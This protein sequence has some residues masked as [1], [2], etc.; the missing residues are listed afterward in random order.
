MG[1][2]REAFGVSCDTDRDLSLPILIL[3]NNEVDV[4]LSTISIV[5]DNSTTR[6]CRESKVAY[7]VP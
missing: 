7:L 6:L 4:L 1:R 5:R 3:K 2:I